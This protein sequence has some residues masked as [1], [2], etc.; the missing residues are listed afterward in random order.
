MR[1]VRLLAALLAVALPSL[2]HAH[3]GLVWP[4]PRADD[5]SIKTAPCGV[6]APGSGVRT[7]LIAGAT[8]QV[9]FKETI[10]H[11]GWFQVSFAELADTNFVVLADNIPHSDAPPAPSFAAPRM[12]THPITVPSTPC[13]ACALRLIQVMTDRNPPTYYYS[14]ADIRIVPPG[15]TPDA[16]GPGDAGA[17]LDAGDPADASPSADASPGAD[18]S[19]P[20]ADAASPLPDAG[21]PLPDAGAASPIDA[22]VPGQHD[23]A[24]FG[25]PDANDPA[26]ALERPSR[27]RTISGGCRCVRPGRS[28][29]G[30][31]ALLLIAIGVSI[32]RAR[33][34][35]R[36]RPLR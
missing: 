24:V 21:G 27:S 29:P 5:S 17:P 32:S 34:R 10:N 1:V 36:A 6:Y 13:E 11:P 28:A 31:A 35:P 20:G 2:A 22:G 9:E 30:S 33:A 7:E 18:A 23:A 16:G 4:T 8:I 26:H 15:G 19:P 25:G 12:Y 14:C 3:A